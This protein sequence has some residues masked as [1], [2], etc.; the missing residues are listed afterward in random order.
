MKQT[1][2]RF[3]YTTYLGE[4]HP[5]ASKVVLE[6]TVKELAA[7]AGLTQVQTNKLIKVMGA[8]Y[9]P[10]KDLVKMSCEKFENQAQNKR[11]LGDLV[12]K[13]I[14]ESKT[15][16]MFEDVP[17]DFRHHTSK[18]RP[19]FPESWAV[20]QKEGVQRLSE[21]REQLKLLEPVGEQEVQPVNGGVLMEEYVRTKQTAATYMR[22]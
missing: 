21:A 9:N 13:V 1:P 4:I 11:Y 22:R 19:V 10:D 18:V 14:A 5:A 20:G 2:L 7:S 3:R 12:N 8:R 16:D 17:F 15:G 6:F